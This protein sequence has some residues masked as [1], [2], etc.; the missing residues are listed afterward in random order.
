MTGF[1]RIA[2]LHSHPKL[3]PVHE[4]YLP[5][6]VELCGLAAVVREHVDDVVIPV[7]PTDRDP[8]AAFRRF[9]RRW[10]PDLVGISCFTCSARSAADYARVA[11]EV[12]AFVVVGGYHPTA[13]PEEMLASSAV[14]AV[15]R[16]EGERTF[17]ELV[18]GAALERVLGLSYRDGDRLVHNPDRPLIEDLDSLPLPLRGIRPPRFG[19]AGTDYHTDTVYAS[20]GFRGRCVFCANRLVGKRRR[21][22][23]NQ[24]VMQELL[25]I[26]PPRRGRWKVV[27]FWDPSFLAEPERVEELCKLILEHGLERW[28]RFIAETRAEDVVAARDIIPTMRAAG[29]CRVGCGIESPL[30]ET[31]KHLDKGINLSHVRQAAELL[32]RHNIAFAK[33]LI[34]GHDTES[35]GDVLR[36]PDY[37]LGLGSRLQTTTFFVMTPYPGTELEAQLRR[38]GKVKSSDYDLYNNFGA[39]I[40]AGELSPLELQTLHC[41]VSAEY[42]MGRRFLLGK[43]LFAVVEKL[44]EHLAIHAKLS[45]LNDNHLRPQVEKSLWKVLTSLRCDRERTRAKRRLFDR[46]AVAFHLDGEPP[47]VISIRRQGA[48]EVLTAAVERPPVATLHLSVSLL[49]TITER[50]NHQILTND[51]LTLYWRPLGYRPAW[52]PSMAREAGKA[53]LCLAR[54]ALFHLGKTVSRPGLRSAGASA[55]DQ[56]SSAHPGD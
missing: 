55:A 56:D 16:G 31:H 3:A 20:R 49:L 2:L 7:L 52:L 29:F 40:T 25:E 17:E 54:M 9:A 26:T 4:Y 18:R 1:R 19:L 22:R 38:Q 13:L 35:A 27:K 46:L 53:L 12:G 24:T 10:R 43:S 14:D 47:V 44:L 23:S 48:R 50:L 30:R 5:D 33:F 21:Q 39:V 15:V 6:L 8:L 45:R 37:A 11:K 34:V 41:V 36:Y 28:F 42:G 51:A 32:N